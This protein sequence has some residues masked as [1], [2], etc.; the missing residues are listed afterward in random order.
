MLDTVKAFLRCCCWTSQLFAILIPKPSSCSADQ[1]MLGNGPPHGIYTQGAA[2]VFDL[3]TRYATVSLGRP[4]GSNH[5]GRF[6][7]FSEKNRKLRGRSP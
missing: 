3:L 7:S 1:L 2:P 5:F 4:I 6:T